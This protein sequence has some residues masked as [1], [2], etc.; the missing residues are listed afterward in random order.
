DG[1]SAQTPLVMKAADGT[2]FRFTA[3]GSDPSQDGQKLELLLHF[4]ADAAADATAG[5]ARNLAAAKTL[6]D[7]HKELRQGF[8]GV[9]VF[10]DSA[11]APPFATEIKMADIP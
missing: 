1:I 2:E 5:R 10:A 6:L 3:L 8:D 9:L 4:T 11:G 7:A